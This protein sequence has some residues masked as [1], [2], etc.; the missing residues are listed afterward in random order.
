MC[1]AGKGGSQTR[2][3]IPTAAATAAAGLSGASSEGLGHAQSGPVLSPTSTQQDSAIQPSAKTGALT[4]GLTGETPLVQVVGM[5]GNLLAG[6]A[7]LAG[8]SV[9]AL[10][11]IC[12]VAHRPN[13][14]N[15]CR[16]QNSS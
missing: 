11:A 16:R 15:H 10:S 8:V 4:G 6:V 3:L 13:S 14:G 12:C 7:L 9:M 2:S 1:R 5:T